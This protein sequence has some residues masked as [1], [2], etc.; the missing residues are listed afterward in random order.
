M[1]QRLRIVS[2]RKAVDSLRVFYDGV[3][4]ARFIFLLGFGA[5]VCF[6]FWTPHPHPLPVNGER[7]S[8]GKRRSGEIKFGLQDEQC[9][10]DV[11][12]HACHIQRI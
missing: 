10:T 7:G 6:C 8:G 2:W 9:V 5:L 11:K 12:G 4:A 1:P 3:M